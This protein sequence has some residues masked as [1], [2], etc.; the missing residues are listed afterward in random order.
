MPTSVRA[1]ARRKLRKWSLT[2]IALVFAEP[3]A[4]EREACEEPAPA[5]AVEL[6]APRR[7]G[8]IAEDRGDQRADRQE[9][10]ECPRETRGARYRETE[11]DE[12]EVAHAEFCRRQRV[13]EHDRGVVD[14][15]AV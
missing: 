12:R 3:G 11:Q 4:C 6:F 8:G 15:T 14:R 7:R 2:P 13:L 5:R 1:L 9:P 10:C